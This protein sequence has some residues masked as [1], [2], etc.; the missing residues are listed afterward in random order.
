MSSSPV[1]APTGAGWKSPSLTG[2]SPPSRGPV[3]RE[4]PPSGGVIARTQELHRVGND[5]DCLALGA[6][7]RLPLAPV[8]ASVDRHRAPLGEEARGVLALRTPHLH[9]EVVGLVRP[10]PAGLVLAAGVARDPQLAHGGAA[11]QRAQLGVFGQVAGHHDPVDVRCGHGFFLSA[12]SHPSHCGASSYLQMK[13]PSLEV[14]A[15][16]TSARLH[17]DPARCVVFQLA[18]APRARNHGRLGLKPRAA[19]VSGWAVDSRRGTQPE[20]RRLRGEV[21]NTSSQ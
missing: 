13:S 17:R 6:V 18:G 9:V 4:A 11:G 21:R 7:L 8:Q 20:S 10:L 16:G 2:V 5:I 3:S 15:G 14:P 12:V 19:R 1:A